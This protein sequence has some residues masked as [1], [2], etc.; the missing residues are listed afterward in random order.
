MGRVA[1]PTP[2]RPPACPRFSPTR[3]PGRP[4]SGVLP[5]QV[6]SAP[7][8]PFCCASGPSVLNPAAWPPPPPGTAP[9]AARRPRPASPQL[10][11]ST[12]K[13]R[14]KHSLAS[15]TPSGG[16]AGEGVF[17]LSSPTRVPVPVDRSGAP[18]T[19]PG[20]RTGS[21]GREERRRGHTHAFAVTMTPE[22][23]H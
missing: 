10:C 12:P 4:V 1:D 3:H 8:S 11:R 15:A 19:R 6:F 5:G 16:R 17:P 7:L 9:A 21:I 23:I 14:L 2:V 18:E 22:E 20:S 13:N